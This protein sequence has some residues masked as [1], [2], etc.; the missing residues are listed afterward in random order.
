MSIRPKRKNLSSPDMSPYVHPPIPPFHL[1]PLVCAETQTDFKIKEEI[2]DDFE[3]AYTEKDLDYLKTLKKKSVILYHKFIESK[4]I[5]IDRSIQ[6]KD[7]LTIDVTNE[8][9]ATLLEKYE[10]VNQLIPY[11]QDYFDC[12]NHL[13]NLFNRYAK[14][15]LISEDPDV[16]LFKQKLSEMQLSHDYRVLIEEKID[17]YQESEGD[18]KSKL[19]RWLTLCTQLP[20]DKMTHTTDDIVMKLQETKTYL[21]NYLFGMQHV[22]ERL[23]IF[24]NKK[25]RNSAGS[26]GCNLA[27]IGKPGVGKCLHP[28]TNVRMANLT[29]K[30]AKD[31]QTGEYLMGDDCTPRRVT[32]TVTGIEEMF[33]ITQ[34]FGETY[35]VNKS[36]ILT[37]MRKDT[38]EIVDLQLM[39][40]IGKEYLY[41]PVSSFYDGVIQETDSVIYGILYS[42]EEK[43]HIILST[44]P[45]FPL[46]PSSYLEWTLS[47]KIAFYMAF[48][49]N[50]TKLRVYIDVFYKILPII[51]L[52]KSAGIRCRRD[53]RYIECMP[54]GHLETFR[55]RPVGLGHYC[56]FTIT[57]NERFL[58]SDW[59][60]THNTAIAK[61]LSKCLDLP[62]SQVSFGGVTS[63]EFLLG[64]D[65]TYIG[66]RPGEITRCLSRMGTKNG[67]LFF[68][69][70]DKASERKEIMS[71]LLHVT[72]FS[73]NNEFRDNY[74][75]EFCQDLSKVWFI[76]SMNELPKDPAMLDRLEIIK[77]D[78]YSFNEKKMIAKQYLFPKFAN[79]LH[80][81]NDF[82]I[83]EKAI[84]KLIEMDNT[85]G[86]RELERT[87][88]LLMEKMYFFLYNRGM[89]YEYD[90]FHK[91]KGEDKIIVDEDLI[92]MIVKKKEN[93]TYS[94][95]YT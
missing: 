36:H 34:E 69:E 20:F 29:I 63:S 13:R 10:S 9:R 65:Y 44:P 18:E 24:L 53:K 38:Q 4:K 55:I 60:V 25:L 50:Q 78:G 81:E 31:I 77:V 42:G 94:N 41:T 3:D 32:S 48:T 7:I 17:E 93:D 88:N 70:F 23:L 91:M 52:L 51:D 47:D 66:S 80:I 11:T 45:L 84:D 71:T 62:F 82:V 16:E 75:P 85:D 74:F 57:E 73:Q 67:I 72:D 27:L 83:D 86:V 2:N 12:R 35:T 15:K 39:D 43:K 58:L 19:K 54:F 30:R 14:K 76:Y 6:L 79:E 5:S 56:G 1:T 90:W 61:A 26:K 92:D 28:Y 22:K 46:L 40:V 33:E 64:H 87:I 59:T 8:K 68:D 89:D 37:L 21:D 95:L 49:C